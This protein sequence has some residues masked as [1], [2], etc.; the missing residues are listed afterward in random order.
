MMYGMNLLAF[1]TRWRNIEHFL[2]SNTLE[3]FHR[4]GWISTAIKFKDCSLRRL[5]LMLD[6]IKMG[7]KEMRSCKCFS[8]LIFL[9]YETF[10]RFWNHNVMN[11]V[12]TFNSNLIAYCKLYATVWEWTSLALTMQ[13]GLLFNLFLQRDSKSLAVKFFCKVE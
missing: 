8:G 13:G 11:T 1:M 3:V 2:N 10:D 12:R 6:H 7:K 9:K 4:N 5:L